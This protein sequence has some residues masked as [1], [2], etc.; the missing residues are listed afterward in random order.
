MLIAATCSVSNGTASCANVPV[1]AWPGEPGRR[2]DRE[3]ERHGERPPPPTRVA[4]V[5]RTHQDER[6][7]GEQQHEPDLGEVPVARV[8]H[9]AHDRGVEDLRQRE[10]ARVRTLEEQRRRSSRRTAG[11]SRPTRAR[12]RANGAVRAGG[13]RPRTRPRRSAARCRRTRPRARSRRAR[14]RSCSRCLR[15][16]AWPR[17]LRRSTDECPT[18]NV[19]APCTGCESAEITRHVSTYAPLSRWGTL[20]SIE[21]S[22]RGRVVRRAD[23]DPVALLVE[24]LDRSERDLDVLGERE[25]RAASARS[26]STCSARRARA[27]QHRVRRSRR[28]RPATTIATASADARRASLTSAGA[29][30]PRTSA[31]GRERTTRCGRGRRSVRPGRMPIRRGPAP[32]ACTAW[33]SARRWVVPARL[34]RRVAALV[35]RRGRRCHAGAS[36]A[37]AHTASGPR[38]TNY[39]TTLG[40][41][42]PRDPGRDRSRRRA[43]QQ[44]R[45]HEPHARSTS[46]CSATT[47]S[48]TCASARAGLY[49]NLRSSATYLNRTRAGTTPIPAIAMGTG[50]STPP[51]WHRVSGSHTAIWHDHRIHW[52]G[53]SPPPDGAGRP[54]SVPHDRSRSGRSCSAYAATTVVGA[55]LVSTGFPGR[56]G[57]RGSRSSSRCSRSGFV[58]AR[59]RGRGRDRGDRR[60]GRCRHGAHDHRGGRA[61]RN[62]TDEDRAVLRRQL[63]VGDRVDRGRG[64]DLGR[65][66]AGG[67]KRSTGSLLVGAMVALVS[68]VTDLSYLWKSQLPTV[69][70]ARRGRAARSR[71]RSGSGSGWRSGALLALRRSTPRVADARRA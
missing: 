31:C 32:V 50:A 65:S 27:E 30:S 11:S 68:G 62:P 33:T 49:E 19:K 22:V 67:S 4:S 1:A 13:S 40:S 26:A 71:S 60:A 7:H 8:Q 41:I 43:R 12:R 20:A 24:Q 59:R 64:H 18:V 2:G 58:V 52:M 34:V 23:V 6:Q 39:L 46:S 66:G 45:A 14:R 53:T 37:S 61:R 47:V 56:A 42:S 54:G 69:G 28:R 3:A 17:G 51:R 5:L 35:S 29:H 16:R 38:P 70:A 25:L 36:P 10:R 44:A 55:R 9:R 21:W 15:L 48:R 57:G 63:R